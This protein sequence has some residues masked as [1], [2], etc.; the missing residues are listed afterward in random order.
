MGIE[1]NPI[2]FVGTGAEVLPRHWSIS[3]V[4]D[5]LVLDEEGSGASSRASA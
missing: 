1:M 3:D 2:G 4:E 5:E